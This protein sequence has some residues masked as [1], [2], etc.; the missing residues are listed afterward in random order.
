M[1]RDRG[2]RTLSGLAAR[3]IRTVTGALA[4]AAPAS[5][6]ELR[7]ALRAYEEARLDEALRSFEALLE[8]GDDDRGR[9]AT[10]ALHL[11]IL[12]CGARNTDRAREAFLLLLTVRP[13]ATL[14]EGLGP[15][16]EDVFVRS[17]QATSLRRAPP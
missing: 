7:D 3:V 16:V 12:Q 9:L 5:A 14:P 13:D 4:R 17:G 6:D 15:T 10:V 1:G 8:H 2:G 11:G